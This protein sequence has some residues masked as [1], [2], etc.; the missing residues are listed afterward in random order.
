MEPIMYSGIKVVTCDSMR[1]W[2]QARTHKKTRIN[3]KWL[4]R[5]GYKQVPDMSTIRIADVPGMGKVLF[6]HPKLYEKI[7][8]ALEKVG[9]VYGN[10]TDGEERSL[11]T[12]PALCA[13][14][15]IV[16]EASLGAD[17]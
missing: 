17:I 5:Y 15:P 14:S 1:V 6:C 8:G 12:P 16:G 11:D 13:T 3:K 4:K 9:V 2:V 10:S 7:K